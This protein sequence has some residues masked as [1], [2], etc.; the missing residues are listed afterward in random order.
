MDKRQRLP[1]KKA[2]RKEICLFLN[3]FNSPKDFCKKMA[4]YSNK[5]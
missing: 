3:K 1:R 4:Q 5:A 2:H